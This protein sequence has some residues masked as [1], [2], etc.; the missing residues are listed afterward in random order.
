MKEFELE[1]C[2]KGNRTYVQGP[3]IL[4]AVLKILETNF[5]SNQICDIKYSAHDMLLAN[6]R[7]VI[8]DKFNNDDYK[9]INSI[10]TFKID[11]KKY[12]AVVTESDKKIVCSN[13]YSEE[14]VRNGSIIDGSKI[15][16]KNVLDDSISEL[17]VSMNKYFLQKTVREDTK[18]IVTKIE[19]KNFM[20]LNAVKE[21]SLRLT[22]TNNFNNKLTK[23]TIH[24]ED[25]EIGYLYFSSI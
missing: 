18:W 5:D 21:K 23:S 15:T 1:F 2:F 7:L 22:L 17:I 16:F 3:D 6:A 13:A 9:K 8:T 4:D 11:N 19:Y 20:D 14:T 10:V 25:K 24:V 12:Y